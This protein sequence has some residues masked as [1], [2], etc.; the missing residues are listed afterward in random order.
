[1]APLWDNGIP[2]V[3]ERLNVVA[4]AAAVLR[5]LG[6]A[7]FFYSDSDTLF[8]HADQRCYDDDGV[9]SA[10]RAARSWPIVTVKSSARQVCA[11]PP[12]G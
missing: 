6:N 3:E 2:S 1:M 12:S 9:M 7:N 10:L 4:E 11:G 5:R 8:L